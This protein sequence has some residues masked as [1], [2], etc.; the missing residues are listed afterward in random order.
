MKRE[1]ITLIAAVVVLAASLS[2][3]VSSS[4]FKYGDQAESVPVAEAIDPNLPD[5]YNDPV[6]KTVFNSKAIDPAQ[7]TQIG[8]QNNSSPFR[9]TR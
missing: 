5:V 1:D 4:L 6:Y 2:F 7:L 9:G 8:S 3:V